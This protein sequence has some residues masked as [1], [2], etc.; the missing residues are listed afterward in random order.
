LRQKAFIPIEVLIIPIFEISAINTKK[1]T[2]IL[3]ASDS[4]NTKHP[5]H[6]DVAVLEQ[7]LTQLQRI[8]Y[9]HN[10]SIDD[11]P[12][13]CW[14]LNWFANNQRGCK[15]I[16]NILKVYKPEEPTST[17]FQEIFLL[18]I[19]NSAL[20]K[21]VLKHLVS[22]NKITEDEWIQYRNGKKTEAKLFGIEESKIS[23]NENKSELNRVDVAGESVRKPT[24]SLDKP[25][26]IKMIVQLSKDPIGFPYI[27]AIFF[28]STDTIAPST[29]RASSSQ[30]VKRRVKQP[31]KRRAEHRQHR[32]RLGCGL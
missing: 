32:R 18:S 22:H 4:M 1:K 16:A 24:E 17:L 26:A 14:L 11:T 20:Y 9:Q 6:E 21:N 29:A 10:G 5:I 2:Q 27:N 8:E 25:E 28:I 12:A 30:R 13:L 3:K 7:H 15:M 23:H 31:V 19:D